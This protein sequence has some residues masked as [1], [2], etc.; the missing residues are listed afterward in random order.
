MPGRSVGPLLTTP[1]STD[2]LI[3]LLPD[4]RLVRV[5]HNGTIVVYNLDNPNNAE[6]IIPDKLFAKLPP[7]HTCKGGGYKPRVLALCMS[8]PLIHCQIV[9]VP[10]KLLAVRRLP[11]KVA[12]DLI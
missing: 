6:N 1:I 11:T 9:V 8:H 7:V 12:T 3:S 10:V 4:G 2:C 5:K